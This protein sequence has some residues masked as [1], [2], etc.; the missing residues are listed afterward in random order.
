[1]FNHRHFS[2][3]F[4]TQANIIVALCVLHNHIRI[5]CG[6]KYWVYEEYDRLINDMGIEEQ[7]ENLSR[8]PVQRNNSTSGQLREG[9]VLRDKIAMDMWC[10][11]L[12]VLRRRGHVV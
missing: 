2:Y 12:N 6:G 8:I 5:E 4:A 11:H 7:F 9:K 1:M 10:D 3:P